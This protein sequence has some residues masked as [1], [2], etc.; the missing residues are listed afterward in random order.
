M[1]TFQAFID[2]IRDRKSL[3]VYKFSHVNR[4]IFDGKDERIIG[5][6][7]T[8][9]GRQ[10]IAKATKEVIV[11]AGSLNSPKILML[12]GIGPKEHLESHGV[13]IMFN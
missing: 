4:L 13:R 8:R 3:S 1:G 12:S 5:V 10:K 11:S 9:H 6:E 7:Y 2:P